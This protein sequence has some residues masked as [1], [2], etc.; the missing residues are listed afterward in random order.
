[1]ALVLFAVAGLALSASG[2]A[3]HARTTASAATHVTHAK[4]PYTAEYAIS[5]VQTLANGNTITRDDTEVKAL[6]SQ[7]R[8][9]TATTTTRLSKD[10]TLVTNV[11]VIDPVART[12]T[13]WNSLEK[14]ATVRTIGGAQVMHGCPTSA[15]ATQVHGPARTFDSKPTVENLGTESIQ[16]LEAKGTR[17]TT[18][19][20]AGTIGNEAPL[21]NTFERWTA[22]AVDLSRL[23]VREISDDGRGSKQTKELTSIEQS[24]P[25]P[26]VF[27]PPAGYEIVSQSAKDESTSACATDATPSK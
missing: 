15:S 2:Q 23:V 19:I 21:V 17:T 25:D 12:I 10:H 3:T 27:Q 6:D 14:R 16:G 20:P 26:S 5:I 11:Y 7:G 9:M 13:R 18:T 1:M 4:T 22:L 24:E 8:E